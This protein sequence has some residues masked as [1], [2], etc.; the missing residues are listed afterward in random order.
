[1]PVLLLIGGLVVISSGI[2]ASSTSGAQTCS[3]SKIAITHVEHI[4]VVRMIHGKKVTK[5]ISKRVDVTVKVHKRIKRHGKWET[6]VREVAKYRTVTECFTPSTTTVP[7]LAPTSTT[8][9]TTL[10]IHLTITPTTSIDYSG[11]VSWTPRYMTVNMDTNSLPVPING[12]GS[13]MGSY[14]FSFSNLYGNPSFAAYGNILIWPTISQDSVEFV[15]YYPQSTDNGSVTYSGMTY[16]D[17]NGDAVTLNPVTVDF[18][19]S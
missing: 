6:V 11:S 18:T 15:F 13:R 12:D 9:S 19:L 7:V 16:T 3:A 8:T 17:V 4:R 5:T 14:N 1:M 2:A 10:P